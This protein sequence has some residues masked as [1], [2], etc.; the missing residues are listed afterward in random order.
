M[1]EVDG[2][3]VFRGYI[4]FDKRQT[5]PNSVRHELN[6]RDII[7]NNKVKDNVSSESIINKIKTDID[8]IGDLI[9]YGTPY[10]GGNKGGRPRKLC[11]QTSITLQESLYISRKI[12]DGWRYKDFE[13]CQ[14]KEASRWKMAIDMLIHLRENCT[15]TLNDK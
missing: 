3:K 1:K 8:I 6:L 10:L 4:Q 13:E 15:I 7:C 14:P 12:F 11:D 2:R 5:S 9:E